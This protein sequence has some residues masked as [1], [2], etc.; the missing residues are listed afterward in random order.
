MIIA[1]T[2]EG[3]KAGAMLVWRINFRKD[4]DVLG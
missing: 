1:V 4:I 2:G 3:I